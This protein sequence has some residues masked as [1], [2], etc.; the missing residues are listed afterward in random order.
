MPSE[1]KHLNESAA[2]S[3]PDYRRTRLKFAS[4]LFAD[5]R[6]QLQYSGCLFSAHLLP[7]RAG[8]SP[9]AVGQKRP[10]RIRPR[11]LPR[12][13]QPGVGKFPEGRSLA[14]APEFPHQNAGNRS[15]AVVAARQV[16]Q[17]G[18]QTSVSLFVLTV[19]QPILC[20][21][22]LR[23]RLATNR[24]SG[25]ASLRQHRPFSGNAA[26]ARASRPYGRLPASYACLPWFGS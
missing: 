6:K 2:P 10:L 5:P 15:I 20:A 19:M 14:A 24:R 23:Q 16:L 18:G 7:L 25:K 4:T 12:S 21:K 22:F 17:Q 8:G 3:F 11:M 9:R 26:R 13:L 1:T